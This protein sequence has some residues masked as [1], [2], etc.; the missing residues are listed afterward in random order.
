MYIMNKLKKQIFEKEETTL[1]PHLNLLAFNGFS[2]LKKLFRGFTLL[3]LI[4]MISFVAT[5]LSESSSNAAGIISNVKVMKTET[6]KIVCNNVRTRLNEK[7]IKEVYTYIKSIAPETK[8]RAELIVNLCEKYN[9]NISFVLAQGI[10]ESHLGTRGLA[11]KTNSVWNVGSFDNGKIH[12]TY[13]DPNESIEPYLKLLKEKY[14]TSISV[15]G[16]TTCKKIKNLIQD[17]GFVNSEGYRYATSVIYENSLRNIMVKI[18]M[19]SSIDLYQG[20]SNLSDEDIL[21]FSLTK[22]LIDSIYLAHL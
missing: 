21:G 20:I 1:K 18:N 11:T 7:L 4:L 17:R 8:I 15:K 12:Y 22:T 5:A 6:N 19:E 3:F 16:D 2:Q 10:L 13:K 14:L 9:M